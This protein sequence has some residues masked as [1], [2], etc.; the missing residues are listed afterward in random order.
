MKRINFFRA[1]TVLCLALVVSGTNVKAQDV[2]KYLNGDLPDSLIL[3][4]VKEIKTKAKD[5]TY[6]QVIIPQQGGVPKD[7]K[8]KTVVVNT[9]FPYPVILIHGVASSSDT[10]ID[11]YNYAYTQ[12]WSYGGTMNFCL[13]SDSNPYYSNMTDISDFTN[14]LTN[15]DLY[16]MNF[17][18]DANGLAHGN[19]T[20]NSVLSNEAAIYKQGVAVK[21][22]IAHVLAVSGKD[23]VI[24]LA[25]SMGG[26]AT[27]QYL[28]NSNLWQPDGKHHIAKYVTMGTPHGGSN[29][30][31][32]WVLSPFIP[33]DE[34]SD[35]VRDLRRYYF[36]SWD[37]GVFLHGGTEDNSTMS[38]LLFSDFYN[39][40]VNCNAV[41]GQ[42][43]VGLNQK[44]LSTNLDFASVIG[45]W[46]LDVTGTG[47]GIV[48]V[49]DAQI[50]TFYP[51]VASETFMTNTTHTSLTSLIKEE[52]LGLDEPDEFSLG[53]KIQ[54]DTL[55]NGFITTQ[56]TDGLYSTDYDQYQF[57][58]TAPGNIIIYTGNFFI[59]PYSI[60][61]FGTGGL[62]Y[63]TTVNTSSATSVPIALTV[64]TYSMQLSAMPNANSWMYPYQ[65]KLNYTPSNITDV[66]EMVY[67]N[68]I[69][70]DLY[71]NPAKQLLNIKKRDGVKDILSVSITDLYGSNV[72]E[73]LRCVDIECEI[74][75]VS[76]LAS[77]IY[78]ITIKDEKHV[79]TL[80][81][82][83]TDDM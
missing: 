26:L 36:Y 45:D 24:I 38:D 25:H 64:G 37:P 63:S 6:K 48:D 52:F 4:H 27:R 75:D 56:A 51:T 31:G 68:N 43:I 39:V 80:R 28:Q 22:A 49:V 16:L 3:E 70:Y 29:M 9:H 46:T 78:F 58:L 69:V 81:F 10:W 65:L 21:K 8:A 19:T 13:D 20:N 50:K 72:L 30:T 47:D 74:F 62:L 76:G 57:K 82:I 40:D 33:L 15:A 83:K 41:L 60:K 2:R 35:A 66:A 53:Y 12:G 71:P 61:L 34:Q 17:N 73:H 23:K 14:G 44:M 77:G 42:T 59:T 18:V 7:V 11:F 5:T 67:E 1:I 54:K 32:T 55:Y 79:E